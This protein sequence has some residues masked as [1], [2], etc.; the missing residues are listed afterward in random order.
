[1]QD[2][3]EVQWS[4]PGAWNLTN[5]GVWSGKTL[6]AGKAYNIEI[7]IKNVIEDKYA[8][9]ISIDGEVWEVVATMHEDVFHGELGTKLGIASANAVLFESPSAT[10]AHNIVDVNVQIG[11]QTATK[12]CSNCQVAI[13][14]VWSHDYT[15]VDA[16]EATCDVAGNIAYQI[17]N[18]CHTMIDANGN[19]VTDVV[20][21]A[22]GHNYELHAEVSATCSTEGTAAHYTCS[23]C[24]KY[25]DIDESKTEIEAPA[26][27]AMSAHS[28]THYDAVS[29][30][31]ATQG[32]I[33]FWQCSIC[34]KFYADANGTTE[35]A[36][37]DLATTFGS[38]VYGEWIPQVDATVDAE[39][40]YGHYHCDVCDKNFNQGFGE[41]DSIVIP[42]LPNSSDTNNDSSDKPADSSK[43]GDIGT[44]STDSNDSNIFSGCFGSIS[45]LS[46]GMI[47]LGVVGLFLKK[48][49]ED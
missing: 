35:V 33:E 10:C 3:A 21:D 38:H 40:T 47:T 26:T 22:L 18:T 20:V 48:K 19:T 30:T 6:E 29:G 16:V 27:L 36:E 11:C 34:N 46:V 41:M 8:I 39:G 43:P 45:G 15:S 4:W 12:A 49:K 37:D 23:A 24:D 17:C 13:D 2:G 7:G 42:K 5:A 9:F 25:F 28:M 14:F 44:D 32:T 31:C 1:M